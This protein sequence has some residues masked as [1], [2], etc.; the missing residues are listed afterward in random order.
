MH[1]ARLQ[2]FEQFRRPLHDMQVERYPQRLGETLQQAIL[3]ALRTLLGLV[4][5]GRCPAR[6]DPQ[7]ARPEHLCQ[8]GGFRCQRAGQTRVSHQQ[9]KRQHRQPAS[10]QSAC[11]RPGS[12]CR[13]VV[14][15]QKT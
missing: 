4:I 5:G 8:G 3:E 10:G 1:P 11:A 12:A 14:P 13:V 6:R 7:H 2:R 15:S 9:C